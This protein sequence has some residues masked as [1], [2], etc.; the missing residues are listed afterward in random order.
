VK[1]ALLALVSLA[2]LVSAANSRANSGSNPDDKITQDE[3]V[4]RTQELV[5]AVAPGNKEP[6][7]K[8]FADDA[9]FFDEKGRSMDKKALVDDI[10]PLPKGYL[11]T[12]KVMN[13]KSHIEGD[14]A[15][16]RVITKPIRGCIAMDNGRSLPRR[17]CATTKT[18]QKAI[19]IRR[20]FRTL[21]GRIN[22]VTAP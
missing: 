7:K 19:T 5:D 12:I 6:W 16:P 2:T 10:Q 17:C 9:M 13:A 15:V 8:Y 4:R 22:W 20:S 14:V 3:L 18:R 21:W 11:G 1:K